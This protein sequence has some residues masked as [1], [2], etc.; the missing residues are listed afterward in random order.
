MAQIN[1]PRVRVTCNA[2]GTSTFSSLTRSYGSYGIAELITKGWVATS[3]LLDYVASEGEAFEEGRGTIDGSGNIVRTTIKRSRHSNGTIDTLVVSFSGIVTIVGT[4]DSTRVADLIT[5]AA[6]AVRADQAQSLSA[7]EQAQAR[8]NAPPFASTTEVTF[9]QSAAPV[10]WTKQ[11]THTDKA[12]RVTSGSIS[13]GGVLDFTTCFARTQTDNFFLSQG[14]LPSVNFILSVSVSDPTHATTLNNATNLI[15]GNS[16]S[17]FG[18]GPV[19]GASTIT[20]NA[21]ATGLNGGNVTGTAASG[22][23]GFGVVAGM[24]MRVK[25]VDLIIA[26]KD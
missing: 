15:N 10:G 2:P 20:A 18:G 24:D 22:G 11:T 1:L 25:Y 7:P 9:H 12:L 3:D 13:S 4:F 6:K 8:A 17:S 26:A 16:G 21:A 5:L 14:N 19:G 23:N